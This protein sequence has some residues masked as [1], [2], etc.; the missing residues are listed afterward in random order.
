MAKKNRKPP[1]LRLL[2]LVV[3]FFLAGDIARAED[4]SSRTDLQKFLSRAMDKRA[5]KKLAAKLA[6]EITLSAHSSGVDPDLL[7]FSFPSAPKGHIHLR[8]EV[9][10]FGQLAKKRYIASILIDVNTSDSDT[11]VVDRISFNDST[12]KIP[13]NQHKI[14]GVRRNLNKILSE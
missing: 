5:Q 8:L 4:A 1:F 7:K 13:A 2:I 12:N 14:G 3:G 6:L 9:E 10:Y 11:W